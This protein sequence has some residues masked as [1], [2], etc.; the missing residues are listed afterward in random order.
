MARR[1]HNGDDVVV[2][3]RYVRGGGYVNFPW[4]RTA[5][6]WVVNMVLSA[7]RLKAVTDADRSRFD[8]AE[9]ALRNLSDQ[10]D[11]LAIPHALLRAIAGRGWHFQAREDHGAG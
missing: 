3:S 9:A 7:Q 1:V 11:E 5:G 6:S 2:A 4:E 8:I 10:L